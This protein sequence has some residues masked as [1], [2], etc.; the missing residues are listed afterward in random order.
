MRGSSLLMLLFAVMA[1]GVGPLFAAPEDIADILDVSRSIED[2]KALRRSVLIQKCQ[3]LALDSEGS[4]A[5]LAVRLFNHFQDIRLSEEVDPGNE[6]NEVDSVEQD[7]VVSEPPTQPDA[8]STRRKR[9]QEQ[10]GWSKF[11]S[12]KSG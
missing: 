10:R 7:P 4:S 1:L 3:S 6:S 11:D 9:T 5:V 2:W 12:C 8:A